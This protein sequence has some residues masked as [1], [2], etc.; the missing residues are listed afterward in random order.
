M[1]KYL[2]LILA[3]V[4]SISGYA[5]QTDNGTGATKSGS[6]WYSTIVSKQYDIQDGNNLD[7]Y[8]SYPSNQ[9]KFDCRR[10]SYFFA[11]KEAENIEVQQKINDSWSVFYTHNLP[12][13]NTWYNP[14]AEL[15]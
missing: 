8:F 5:V 1:K 3:S 6:T 15:I 4:L 12:D 2:L 13:K 10:G 14:L 7:I 11:G 9:V